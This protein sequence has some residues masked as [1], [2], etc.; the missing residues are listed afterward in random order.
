MSDRIHICFPIPYGHGLDPVAEASAEARRNLA[1]RHELI[2][3]EE[4]PPRQLDKELVCIPAVS[5]RE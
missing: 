3:V 1:P 4:A 5:I 2:A